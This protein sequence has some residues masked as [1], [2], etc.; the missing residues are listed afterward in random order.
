MYRV[1]NVSTLNNFQI[2]IYI[3]NM[4]E[5]LESEVDSFDPYYGGVEL[6]AVHPTARPVPALSPIGDS[7]WETL[8][9]ISLGLLGSLAVGATVYLIYRRWAR[10]VEGT[11]GK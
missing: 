9:P 5:M 8:G 1:F 2:F 10:R 4:A 7:V 6:P 3:R 11:S